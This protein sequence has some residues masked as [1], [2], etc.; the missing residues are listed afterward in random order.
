MRAWSLMLVPAL[1]V[2]SGCTGDAVEPAADDGERAWLVAAVEQPSGNVIEFYEMSPGVI[3][4]S[5]I[6]RAAPTLSPEELEQMR[7]LEIFQAVADVDAA[8]PAPLVAAIEREDQFVATGVAPERLGQRPELEPFDVT[9]RVGATPQ[10]STGGSS[11]SCSWS[12]FQSSFCG[13][14][15]DYELCLSDRWYNRSDVFHNIKTHYTMVCTRQGSPKF[16]VSSKHDLAWWFHHEVFDVPAGYWRWWYHN[17]W[18]PH[19]VQTSVAL[20]GY[21]SRYHY[22]HRGNW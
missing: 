12:W 2:A 3:M 22:M 9:E 16:F 15:N 18:Y 14:S 7:T 20:Q 6:G 5:E 19:D 8:A 17:N 21:T 13:T 1:M 10:A 11:S 4:V